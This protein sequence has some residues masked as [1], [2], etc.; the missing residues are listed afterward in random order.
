MGSK[1]SV[2]K[3][4][5]YIYVEG[6]EDSEDIFIL[7]KGAVDLKSASDKIKRYK[8]TVKTGEVF[9]FTSSLSKRPRMESAFARTDSIIITIQR[10][11]FIDLVQN[12]PPIALKIINYF[13]DELRALNDMIFTLGEE[14]RDMVS[15]EI[16]LF[17]VG[18]Y[19]RNKGEY[20][21]ARYVYDKYLR[22]FPGGVYS[23]G[24]KE[25]LSEVAKMDN[26]SLT[27]PI[28]KGIN[29]IFTDRQ[30][31]FSEY[32]SGN[33]LYIIK[34]GKVKITK[35]SNNEEIL[36]SV[37]QEGDIFGELAIVSNKPRNAT[38]ISWG[39]TTLIYIDKSTLTMVL[40]KS[41]QIINRIFMAISQRIW[42]TYIRVEAKLYN[43]PLTRIYIFL[44]NKLLEE[45]ISLKSKEPAT[46]LFG[47]DELMRMTGIM[48]SQSGSIMN[49]ILE[50]SNLSFNMGKIIIDSPN[51]LASKAKFYRSRDHIGVSEVDAK[52]PKQA[53]PVEVN[54]D[55][56]AEEPEIK[57][58]KGEEPEPG[59]AKENAGTGL[60]T[61]DLHIPSEEIN[62]DF[63]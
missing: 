8:D 38:A 36:L 33:E 23:G 59:R 9:G 29:K 4:G 62:I 55:K 13:A 54:P 25:K 6:D 31:I 49:T 37:L 11:K 39:S 43:N 46:L 16:K 45:R 50:D 35:I 3:A 17:N 41:P 32:E 34:E 12:N 2:F 15:D 1:K 51:V 57:P 60:S 53:K 19:Y 58:V 20:S 48:Q 42:F 22:Q 28:K 27:E 7:E 24:V 61:D 52:E 40:E 10:E 21:Y 56:Q 30:I 44:E 5:A 14:E 18:E 47:I 26:R 63:E